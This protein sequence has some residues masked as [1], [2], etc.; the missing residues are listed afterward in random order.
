MNFGGR[1][2]LAG[3]HGRRSYWAREAVYLGGCLLAY[4]NA[5]SNV[6]TDDSEAEEVVRENRGGVAGERQ[7]VTGIMPPRSFLL[8]VPLG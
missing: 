6:R 7:E 2:W 5:A 3:L 4:M 1:S 8:L